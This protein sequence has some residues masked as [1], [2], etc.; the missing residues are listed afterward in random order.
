MTSTALAQAAQAGDVVLLPVGSI[1]Q[2]GSHLPVDTDISGPLETALEVGRRRTW[3]IIAPPVW[4][5]LSV[6][7][8]SFA[9]TITLRTSTFHVLLEDI[10]ESILAGGFKLCLLVGHASNIPVVT[11]LVGEFAGLGRGRLLQ[12]NYLGFAAGAFAE[13]RRSGIGGDAHAGELETS[14][15][16]HLRPDLVVLTPPPQARYVDP[17]RDYGLSQVSPDISI[18]T[19]VTVGYDLAAKFPAGVIGDPT[20]A[21]ADTGAACWEAIVDGVLGVL[22]E[23]HQLK[24]TA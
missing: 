17:K 6:A 15:Q 24:E 13:H 2:H 10:C 11:T 12:L 22:D 19:P 8:S 18:R 20:V 21:S 23:Y 7:H 16:L 4:W 1:E 5:G 14:I 3:T 9:G